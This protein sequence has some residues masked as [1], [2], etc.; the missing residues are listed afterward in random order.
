MKIAIIE[1]GRIRYLVLP[2]K[3]IGNYWITRFD[4][5]GIERNLINIEPDNNRWKIVSNNDVGIY[6]NGVLQP[7]VILEE[8]KFYSLKSE[9]TGEVRII[10]ALPIYDKSY[11]MYD[12]TTN[13]TI[14]IGSN[15]TNNVVYRILEDL[16][17]K[18]DINGG[19][20]KII[21]NNSKYGVYV[22]N[23]RI[24]GEKSLEYGD[25]IFI[26][27]L[28]IIPIKYNGVF[29][30]IINNP[31][32][33]IMFNGIMGQNIPSEN[34]S[35]TEDNDIID[36]KLYNDDNYF[37]KKPRFISEIEELKI[38]VDAP[39]QKQEKEDTSAL[40]TIGPMLTMSMTSLV[41]GYTA[42]NN[43]TSGRNTIQSAMPSLI[44]CGAMFASVFIWPSIMRVY[45][46]RKQKKLEK[47][48]QK[49]YTEYIDSKRKIISEGLIKQK[50][51]LMNSYPSL[52]ECQKIILNT[53][54]ALWQR[55]ISDNDFLMVNLGYGDYPMK[56]N[57]TYPEE[58]FSMEE[59]NL[60]SIVSK[61]GS[62]PK[63]LQS[64][65]FPYS[66]LENNISAI[67]GKSSDITEYTR[68][69]LLQ[70]IAFSSY[71]DLKIA[72]FTN[73]EKMD[74]WQF[75]KVLPHC[76]SND[77]E[78]RYFAVDND[79]Y[80]EVCYNLE[81]VFNK[82]VENFAN[83]QVDVRKN[84]PIYL[85]VTDSIKSVRNFDLIKKIL[86]CDKN[87]GFSLLILNDKISNIP[88]QCKTFI[89]IENDNCEFLTSHYN[90]T[91]QKLK[92]DFVTPINLYKCAEMLSNIPIEFSDNDDG[93]IPEKLSF[94]EMY[95]VG[96]VEQLNASN[97]WKKN[98]PILSLGAPVGYGKNGEK[99]SIDLHEK[100]HGPHGL[101]AGMTGSG[102]SEFIISYIL[103]MAINYHPYEVQFILIDYKGGGLAGAFENNSGVKLPHLVGTITNLDA[104][105]IKRSLASIESE[106]K[107]RQAAFNKARDVSGESTIDIYKYQRL[108]RDGIVDEPISHLFIISDEFAELKKEQ[109]EFMTQLI[110]TARIGRSLGVHLILATQKPSGVV[111]QQI[112]SNTR[113]R[114][115]LRVQEKSD[116]TE[117][118]KCPDAAFLK[119]TGRFYFQVG[120]NE[121]FILGQA[122]WAGAK[123]F[124]SKTIKKE[125]DT[126]INFINNIG[127]PIKTVETRKKQ[128]IESKGEELPNILSYLYKTAAE[129]QIKVRPLWQPKIPAYVNLE[130]LMKK[131]NYEKKSYAVELVV[132]EYDVPSR[133]EQHL[134]TLPLGKDGNALYYGAAG[135]GKE[136]LLIT[137]IYSSMLLYT[138][139]EINFY[140]LDFGA[141]ILKMFKDSSNVGNILNIDDKEEI[142]NLY[143]M[144]EDEIDDRKKLF[145][146]YNGDYETYCKNSGK[147]IPSIAV[148]INNYETYQENY[149][150]YDD[151][152]NIITRECIKYGIY[153]VI[154]VSTPNGVRFKLKQNFQQI[155]SLQQNS[156]D[157]YT[158]IL[159]NVEKT[160]PSKIFGRGIVKFDHA[161]EFQTASVALN[162]EIPEFVKNECLKYSQK[163]TEKAKPI[164]TL[165]EIVTYKDI[166]NEY[167]K[168]NELILGLN[169]NDLSIEKYDF[170]KDYINL[171]TGVELE[172]LSRCLNPLINQALSLNK[173]SIFV[174]NTEKFE[175][176]DR[177]KKYYKYSNDNF[178]EVF[179]SLCDFIEVQKEL[180]K[181]SEL[182]NK[183]LKRILCFIIGI[184]SFKSKLSDDNKNRFNTFFES[185]QDLDFI[186]FIIIDTFDKL[187]KFEFDSWYK[188]CVDSSNGIWIGNGIDNQFVIKISQKIPEMKL[189][190]QPF[191]G[192]AIKRGKPQYIK[193]VGKLDLNIK[194]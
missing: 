90:E 26:M 141:E 183:P 186:N 34:E 135:S 112:W 151:L 25:I 46:K 179:N 81:R 45:N 176:D 19:Q 115:C 164:P 10:Y 172:D 91:P 159:G 175:V 125:I 5:N 48:R 73:K 127:Y 42:I 65:P 152:L 189:D 24:N 116:S 85:I 103:S 132:G 146:E 61:L 177:Y 74:E 140:I 185:G 170:T 111:D 129:E 33:S 109:P 68:R 121:I 119:N 93:K 84:K 92:I 29:Y 110:S 138:P 124:P 16:S 184:E 95:D 3:V 120:Y 169:K 155:Y 50:Q 49:K 53:Q 182:K 163:Y 128:V 86:E 106:L 59:D 188:K 12:V 58:H 191:F 107:R 47:K 11:L 78:I 162:E 51:I 88:D 22:N 72:V 57:I 126:N 66:F 145:Y 27:G 71:D 75:C 41:S 193:F 35:Y 104:N 122:A 52:D 148:I 157:D 9:N 167:G 105:E 166:K 165:P 190:I 89:K 118:I 113:F 142:N 4:E 62:E 43:V 137:L 144:L 174:I 114:V 1:F 18:I 44:M 136:N 67:V 147:I 101:I 60:K 82:R 87:Y 39:P 17:A 133:Q 23:S 55:R 194:E 63:T 37:H 36:M 70:I 28:K 96:E 154:T 13:N 15:M 2:N 94:L 130:D 134:L 102:K 161:Y 143:K 54:T 31:A 56:I 21:D 139:S 171:Y 108:Y 192:F 38:N 6:S 80:K 173:Y 168:G 149:P 32:N 64:A 7:I 178:N 160:Y 153:F 150:E 14:T 158:T 83:S 8:Y 99:I 156:N 100:F 131:Y 98:N 76:F 123:Y 97:R 180:Y 69:L 79:D 181:N 30:L 77:K 40:L 117:V 187:K 20:F